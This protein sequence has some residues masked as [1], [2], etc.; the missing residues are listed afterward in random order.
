M[1]TD[2][3]GRVLPATVILVLLFVFVIVATNPVPNDTNII[4]NDN[5]P[6]GYIAFYDYDSSY[7]EAILQTTMFDYLLYSWSQF[8]F[9]AA[10]ES[11]RIASAVLKGFGHVL[12]LVSTFSYFYMSFDYY[13]NLS[14]GDGEIQRAKRLETGNIVF[15][16]LGASI[17][18][19]IGLAFGPFGGIIGAY[20][21]A[22]IAN[23]VY[24][25]TVY[26]F[27]RLRYN[28]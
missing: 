12:S 10:K 3:S 14:L 21:G 20:G 23:E 25:W 11:P 8:F 7:F 15:A 5:L 16:Y 22:T 26:Q 4:G 28:P 6:P 19:A 17:G 18:G 1:Y 9:S 27:Y 13:G 2:P 24:D